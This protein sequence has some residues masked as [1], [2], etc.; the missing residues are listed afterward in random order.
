MESLAAPEEAQAIQAE[1][2]ASLTAE[3]EWGHKAVGAVG[4]NPTVTDLNAAFENDESA[5]VESRRHNACTSLQKLADDN[6]ID[7]DMSC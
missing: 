2:V 3:A 7:V 6:S 1:A 5:A 4:R